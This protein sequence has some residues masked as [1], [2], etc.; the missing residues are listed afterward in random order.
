MIA[1]WTMCAVIAWTPAWNFELDSEVRA[2]A[3]YEDNLPPLVLRDPEADICRQQYDVPVTYRVAGIHASQGVTWIGPK[4]GTLTVI[5]PSA[6][7]EPTGRAMLF[8]G[9]TLLAWLDRLRR[10]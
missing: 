2:H 9:I 4:S 8:A 5:W 1:I 10:R 6:V 3:L 7:P